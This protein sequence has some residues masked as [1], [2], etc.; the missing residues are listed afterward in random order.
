MGFAA[1]ARVT[2]DR[3]I[4]CSVRDDIQFGLTPGGELEIATT[5]CNEIRDSHQAVIIDHVAEDEAFCNHH[6]PQM[7]GFQSYVSFPIVLK[8]GEFFGTLCAIDP[9]PA[10]LNNSKVT[11]MFSL[12]ADLI[13]FHLQQ[14]EL[15][16][17]SQLTVKKLNYQL[18]DSIH[19]N[20]QYQE[21]TNH[22]LQEPLRKL[23]IFSGMLIDATESNDFNKA[24][25]LAHKIDDNA[26]K[27][28]KMIKGLSGFAQLEV[29]DVAVERIDLNELIASVCELL[30][31]KAQNATIQVDVLPIIRGIPSQLELLFY[32]LLNN[33]I[34][35]SKEGIA[36]GVTITSNELTQSDLAEQL[37]DATSANYV[38][39]S[40]TD[41]GIGIEKR[42]LAKIFDVFGNSLTN[43]IGGGTGLAYCRK[44]VRNHNGLLKVKSEIG[45]G[46]TFTIILPME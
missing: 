8:N 40:L 39:I 10:Q 37:S 7:Y 31:T 13:A 1:V 15:L 20:R 25:E 26:Q 12:F 19:E 35:F 9:N 42:Q 11:G 2:E 17:Q 27:F 22:Y 33:A 32:H 4:A 5:I 44:I 21:V 45:Q 28:S 18:T 16:N 36:P 6:T 29:N 14:F 30:L 34:R 3:W 38:E 41:N 23:R 43:K 46:T 24:R